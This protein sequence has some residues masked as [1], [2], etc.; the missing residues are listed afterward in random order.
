[1]NRQRSR[2][3]VVSAVILA[4]GWASAATFT[5]ADPGDNLFSTTNNWV[6]FPVAGEN[7]SSPWAAAT[8]IDNPG[9]L[10]AAFN[11]LNPGG[12]G[13][14]FLN[15]DGTG[16][17]YFEVLSGATWKAVNMTIGHGTAGVSVRHGVLTLKSGSSLVPGSANNGTL[18]IGGVAGGSRGRLTAEDGVTLFSHA[19]LNLR[20]EGTLAFQFGTNSASTFVSTKNNGAALMVLDGAVEVDLGALKQTGSYTL[21]AGSHMDSVLS[22]A[23]ITWLNSNGG[24]TNGTGDLNTDHFDVVNSPGVEWSLT[25]ASSGT[26]LLL[27]VTDFKPIVELTLGSSQDTFMRSTGTNNRADYGAADSM[28]VDGDGLIRG[29]LEFDLSAAEYE[30]TNA[31]LTLTQ[32][33]DRTGDWT[34][35]IYPM[36]YTANNYDWYEG[37]GSYTFAENAD[38]PAAAIGAACYQYSA[39]DATSPIQ[40]EDGSASPLSN[41]IQAG[42]WNASIGSTSGTDSISGRQISFVLD[43]S[44]LEMFRTNGV[45]RI[46]IGVW[47]PDTLSGNHFLATKENAYADW[48][49][50]LDLSM[51]GPV[52][53]PSAPSITSVS[54]SAIGGGSAAT[55]VFDAEQNASLWFTPDL[56]VPTWTN[57]GSGASPLTHTNSTP[58]GFYKVTIP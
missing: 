18:I 49:P 23:L 19:N 36:T 5:G 6:A 47:G 12:F 26:E 53:A 28:F 54:V 17:V 51:D 21:I 44:T 27:T 30:I 55:I 4:A 45:G 40:W 42:L 32:T 22:G 2:L 29:L 24:T 33:T 25:T 10:D 31:V 52:V 11:I 9:Q 8:S 38:S 43:A 7:F 1:M 3:A 35:D 41:V 15:G 56:V 14:T 39:D 13:N 57:V 58:A 20:A 48:R 37:T 46:V 34:F 16:T 50:S